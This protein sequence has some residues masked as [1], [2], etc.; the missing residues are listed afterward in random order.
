[1]VEGKQ[2]LTLLG[3]RRSGAE[4]GSLPGNQACGKG[5]WRRNLRLG[6]F[7]GDFLLGF[8]GMGGVKDWGGALCGEL[9]NSSGLE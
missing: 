1:M 4:V 6:G 3:G 2:T 5:V 9:A 8:L 7:G